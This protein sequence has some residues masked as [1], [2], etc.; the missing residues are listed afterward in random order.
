[1]EICQN[2]RMMKLFLYP[3]INYEII[4]VATK[5]KFWASSTKYQTVKEFSR[6]KKKGGSHTWSSALSGLLLVGLVG[7]VLGGMVQW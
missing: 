4:R 3:V 2:A 5:G 1:M 6:L 7:R